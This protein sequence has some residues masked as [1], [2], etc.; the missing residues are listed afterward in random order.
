MLTVPASVDTAL[1]DEDLVWA[2]LVDLPGG[3]PV[4]DNPHNLTYDGTTYTPAKVLLSAGDV[5]RA[6]DIS[7]DSYEITM[8]N[9]DQAIYEDYVVTNRVGTAVEVFAAFVD[10]GTYDLRAADSVIKIYEGV[11]DSWSVSE[12]GSRASISI[13]L[14]SHWSAWKIVKGR[15][16]N[17]SSQEE[18]YS[19]DTIFEFSHQEELPIK[20]G[21]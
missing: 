13:R 5:K 15:F 8:D 6:Q 17:S 18:T 12:Q 20:W 9:A 19:G 7:A 21:L 4:T 16:T 10:A 3:F 2:L 14:T 1:A 11:L